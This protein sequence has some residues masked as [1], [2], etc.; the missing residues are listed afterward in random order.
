LIR[1]K[2][3]WIIGLLCPKS[4]SGCFLMQKMTLQ[5]IAHKMS[6]FVFLKMVEKRAIIGLVL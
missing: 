3:Q 2:I 1:W 5:R 4:F 6:V